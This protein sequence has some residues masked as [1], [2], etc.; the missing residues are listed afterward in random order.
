MVPVILTESLQEVVAFLVQMRRNVGVPDDNIYLFPNM[1]SANGYFRADAILRSMA[2]ACGAKTP[3]TLRATQLRKH[4]ATM[5]QLLNLRE[6]ELDAVAA[7]MGHDIRVHRQYYRL[8]EDTMQLAKVSKL[9]LAMEGGDIKRLKGC[10]LDNIQVD[11]LIEDADKEDEEDEA[12]DD[13]APRAAKRPPTGT[14]K[15]N[16][17]QRMDNEE[18]RIVSEYFK[19]FIERMQTPG[20]ADIDKFKA[21]YKQFKDVK[22]DKI[23][24]MVYNTFAYKKRGKKN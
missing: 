20:K 10:N 17:R 18:K 6:N 23:K 9:L 24:Y 2:V 1:S 5:T 8:Q 12:V 19:R 13:V 15:E 21:D 11:D 14:Q 22:W 16:T 4:V 3:E 7:Y